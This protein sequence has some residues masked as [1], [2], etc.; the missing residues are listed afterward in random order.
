MYV[1]PVEVQRVVR[2]ERT[3]I[4]SLFAPGFLA[5]GRGCSFL[6]WTYAKYH[7]Q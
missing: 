6:N 7:I 1:L 5:G 2:N 3:E 4:G